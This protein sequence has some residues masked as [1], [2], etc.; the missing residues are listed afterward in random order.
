MNRLEKLIL[1]IKKQLFPYSHEHDIER[2]CER[3]GVDEGDC[4][5]SW[6]AGQLSICRQKNKCA[7]KRMCTFYSYSDLARKNFDI[8][9]EVILILEN[10]EARCSFAKKEKD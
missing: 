6:V 4:L 3:W 1:D 9:E 8:C 7:K 10:G 5:T 2:G